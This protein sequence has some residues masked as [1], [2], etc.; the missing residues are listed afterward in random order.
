MN[1]G[2]RRSRNR[3][4]DRGAG[5]AGF[6]IVWPAAFLLIW[7]VV[8]VGV[9]LYAGHVAHATADLTLA[10]ARGEGATAAQAHAQGAALLTQLGGA[11][12]LEEA[13]ITVDRTDT[14]AT[15]RV[16]GA[17]ATVF[18]GLS[19]PVA[20]ELSGPVDRFVPDPGPAGG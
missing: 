4:R 16:E 8:Q 19:L 12:L 3:G 5:T 7:L 11:G 18:P 9:W 13:T 17:A 1:G 15:V 6:A 2:S 20:V 10:A 14:Q